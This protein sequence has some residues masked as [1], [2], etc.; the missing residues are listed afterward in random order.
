MGNFFPISS[1]FIIGRDESADIVIPLSFISRSHA[2]LII[3]QGV[4]TVE[5]TKSSNGT[6]VNGTRVKTEE[7]SNGDDLRLDEFSFTIIGP[8]KAKSKSA[9]A[10]RGKK[11]S[12]EKNKLSPSQ[13]NQKSELASSKVFLHDIDNKST[14]KVYEIIRKENH[15]SKMLGHHLSRSEM[16]VSARHVYLIESDVG[17]EVLNNGAADGL[18][19]NNSMLIKAVLQD[20]DE[21]TVGGTLLKFQS[22]G[23][24]PRNYYR[25]NKSNS[26]FSKGVVLFA[27]VLVLI[28]V[29]FG[30]GWF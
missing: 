27:S 11:Q 5:D 30:L 7:L 13:T 19:V 12:T 8:E 18:L 28:A 1:G 3:K 24:T 10:M 23:D 21:L 4:L 14:G 15:L 29:G 22:I 16:S 20:G 9:T 25:P 26:A 6:F 2:K 17:W